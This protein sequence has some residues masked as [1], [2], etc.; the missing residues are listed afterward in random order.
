MQVGPGQKYSK[1]VVLTNLYVLIIV[2]IYIYYIIIIYYIIL[3]IVF[4]V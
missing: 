2:D 4:P 1:S 3:Y